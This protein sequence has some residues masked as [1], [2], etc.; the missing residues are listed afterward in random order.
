METKEDLQEKL[1]DAVSVIG[2]LSNVQQKL[3]EARSQYKQLKKQKN[4]N[5]CKGMYCNNISVGANSDLP[6]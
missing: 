1:K 4:D 3:N 6:I 2:Q 5:N